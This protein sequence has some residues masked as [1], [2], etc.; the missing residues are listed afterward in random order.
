MTLV[1]KPRR[2]RRA[3]A[4]KKR[5]KRRLEKFIPDSDSDFALT[6][7]QFAWAIARDPSLYDLKAAD[8]E[9]ISA[10]VSEYRAALAKSLHKF[11]RTQ[12]TI[13]AKDETRKRAAE[14]VS[15]YGELIRAS[16][17][18]NGIDKML[19]RDKEQPRKKKKRHCPDTAPQLRYCGPQDT[20]GPGSHRHVLS[21][22]E[23]D[24]Y[25][26]T[27]KKKPDGA[28]RIEL[29]IDLVPQ[30]VPVP[31]H[32]AE[33]TGREWYL[34]SYTTS[35]MVVAFP[36]PSEPMLVVYWARWAD[37]KGNVGPFSKTCE[38]RVEGWS[39]STPPES[40]LEGTADGVRRVETKYVFIQTP[41][42]LTDQSQEETQ[43]LPALEDQSM[44]RLS[45]L[46]ETSRGSTA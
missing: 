42:A 40:L 17:R 22:S 7:H 5:R 20:G 34:R 29:F 16:R 37:T 3:R 25:G 4:A 9:I 33:L 27:S 8:S 38:A 13:M 46:L 28:V 10:V 39:S 44:A 18:I 26:V 1:H 6:A 24:E 32:P 41:Y 2:D 31:S 45:R 23:S 14:V 12:R 43:S 21:Y 19:V 15:A 30:G 36:M 11:S 35:T